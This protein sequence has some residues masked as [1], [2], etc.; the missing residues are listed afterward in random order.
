MRKLINFEDGLSNPDVIGTAY[1]VGRNAFFEVQLTLAEISEQRSAMNSS[2]A[3]S[4]VTPV[5]VGG[6]NGGIFGCPRVDQ[7]VWIDEHK[8]VKV[9][10]IVGRDDVKLYNPITRK[11]NRLVSATILPDQPLF[12]F[13]T[14]MGYESIVSRSHKVITN[15]ADKVG[16]ALQNYGVGRE[17][18]SFDEGKVGKVKNWN[19]YGDHVLEMSDAGFGDVVEIT[20]ATEFIYACGSTKKGGH[21]AHNLKEPDDFPI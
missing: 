20:L 21:V 1:Q 11:F 18:L 7:Y 15:T 12:K 19:I 9:K 3:S 5:L 8:A 10:S 16:I 13:V 14:G 2:T 6:G 4:S 17:C